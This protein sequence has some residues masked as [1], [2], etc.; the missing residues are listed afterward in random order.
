MSYRSCFDLVFCISL[1]GILC[2][3]VRL[4]ITSLL[5]DVKFR[6]QELRVGQNPKFNSVSN[7]SFLSSCLQSVGRYLF[8]DNG[9]FNIEIQY[10]KQTAGV[11]CIALRREFDTARL[12]GLAPHIKSAE[13]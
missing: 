1:V 9:E 8:C 7:S 3:N 2:I 4:W 10:K 5:H 11:Y 6:I 12:N 13:F